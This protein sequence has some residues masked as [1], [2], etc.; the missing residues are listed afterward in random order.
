MD[1]ENIKWTLIETFL[2]IIATLF[3]LF[4]VFL[5]FGIFPCLAYTPPTF[6]SVNITLESDYTPPSYDSVNLTLGLVD[7]APTYSE[8]STN[9]T[10]AG[11]SIEHSLKWEDETALSGYIFSFCNGTWNGTRSW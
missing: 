3:F 11:A 10:I 8:N 4:L 9:S 2:I 1:I 5:T 6:D 7:T